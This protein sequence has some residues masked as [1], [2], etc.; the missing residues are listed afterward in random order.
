MFTYLHI[1]INIYIIISY[2]STW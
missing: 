2:W 1:Y